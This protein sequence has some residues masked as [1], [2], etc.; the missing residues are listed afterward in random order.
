[1]KIAQTTEITI[2]GTLYRLTA[3]TCD[4]CAFDKDNDKC[5]MIP[6]LTVQGGCADKECWKVGNKLE[7]T[8][9]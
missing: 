8:I 1:M 4:D 2:D 3:G 7:K 6:D 9:N 5:F